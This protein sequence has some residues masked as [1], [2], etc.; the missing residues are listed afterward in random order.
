MTVSIWRAASKTPVLWG[1]P[2]TAYL[3]IFG[4]GFHMAWWT[5]FGAIGSIVAFGVLARYGLTFT[6]LYRKFMGLLR[7]KRI[8]A[9]PWWYRKRFQDRT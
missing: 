9:R 6:V 3:P 7:G 2:C 5:F 8:Y 1:V 4:W